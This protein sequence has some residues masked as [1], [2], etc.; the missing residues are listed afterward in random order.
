MRQT[1]VEL[2]LVPDPLGHAPG[3]HLPLVDALD[4]HVAVAPEVP[5]VLP[6]NEV[7]KRAAAAGN[8]S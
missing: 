3:E 1:A 6:A 5:P 8:A 4:C 7:R 2:H